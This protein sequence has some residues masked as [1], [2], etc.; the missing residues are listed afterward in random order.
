MPEKLIDRLRTCP[1]RGRNT[2]EAADTIEAQAKY[3]RELEDAMTPEL[4]ALRAQ[5]AELSKDAERFRFRVNNPH[6]TV[7]S[8]RGKFR[9]NDLRTGVVGPWF[10]SHEDAIDAQK[11]TK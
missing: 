10:E 2:I 3:I 4:V 8:F 1:E 9:C 6:I 7:D 11:G 5:V